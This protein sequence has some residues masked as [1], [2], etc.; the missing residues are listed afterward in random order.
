MKAFR[1]AL[2]TLVRIELA[3][4]ALLAMYIVAIMV[5][6]IVMRYVFNNSIIWVQESVMLAF[7][8]VTALGA[9]CAMA[10]ESHILIDT[11]VRALPPRL[12]SVL[13]VLVSLAVLACLG[14][15]VATLPTAIR[16]QNKSKTASL[17]VNFPK[18]WYYSFPILVSVAGMAAARLYYL[19]YEVRELF[20]LANP[21]DFRIAFPSVPGTDDARRKEE[22]L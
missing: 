22:S 6:E 5:V 12:R 4:G 1:R 13:R 20:G 19:V 21:G 9:A 14:F 7:I 8:W 15:L 11:L 17:P 2:E 16:I 3:A 10:T 18:G